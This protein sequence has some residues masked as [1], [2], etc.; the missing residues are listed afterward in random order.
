MP[1]IRSYQE[2]PSIRIFFSL[3]KSS[4]VVVRTVVLVLEVRPLSIQLTRYQL[5]ENIL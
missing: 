2:Y 5:L 4:Y 1:T 3:S